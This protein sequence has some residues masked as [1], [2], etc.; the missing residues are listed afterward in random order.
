[1][2]TNGEALAMGIHIDDYLCAIAGKIMGIFAASGPY[3]SKF[4]I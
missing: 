1:M 3:R 4:M 2:G